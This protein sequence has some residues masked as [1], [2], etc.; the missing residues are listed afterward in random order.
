MN[1]FKAQTSKSSAIANV[2]YAGARVLKL[3]SRPR[4]VNRPSYVRQRRRCHP[5]PSRRDQHQPLS[6]KHRRVN[7][8]A[9]DRDNAGRQKSSSSCVSD[10]DSY[11]SNESLANLAE[12]DD[13]TDSSKSTKIKIKNHA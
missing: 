10:S 7:V 11:D 12:I 13:S 6:F 3:P 8:S 4:L 1:V 9:G 5:A 2:K